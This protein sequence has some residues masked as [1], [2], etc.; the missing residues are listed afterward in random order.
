M[1]TVDMATRLGRSY[2]SVSNFL[3]KHAKRTKL[4]KRINA[5]PFSKL[6]ETEV[7][8][9]AGLIDGE[10]TI[11][12]RCRTKGQYCQPQ[13]MVCNTSLSLAEWLEDRGFHIS[14]ASNNKGRLYWRVSITGWTI[15]DPLRR[16]LPYLVVKKRQA[17][18]VIEFIE[19]RLSQPHH[20]KP[21][22]R[23]LSIVAELR[24]LHSRR[25]P[26]G[27]RIRKPMSTIFRPHAARSS[28]TAS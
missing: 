3:R 1:T 23:M 13:V 6:S 9:V 7:V 5:G 2:H 27:E 4:T 21:S 18:L 8:Y 19:L 17:Q 16:L 11:T 26:S 24:E 25:R 14:W 22:E 15:I 28:R 20:A 12:V 10:G